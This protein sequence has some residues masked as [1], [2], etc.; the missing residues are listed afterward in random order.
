MAPLTTRPSCASTDELRKAVTSL[1][2][3]L[4]FVANDVSARSLRA[5]G[6]NALFLADV[7][8]NII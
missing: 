6:A 8:A 4:G 7:N 3:R 1:G 2:T 5:A